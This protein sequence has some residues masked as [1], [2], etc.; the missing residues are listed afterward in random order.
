[1]HCHQPPL[2][3]DLPCKAVL[4][5]EVSVDLLCT[6]I[7]EQ[8][9]EPTSQ[10]LSLSLL[11]IQSRVDLI[12]VLSNSRL[13]LSRLGGGAGANMGEGGDSIGDS[14]GKGICGVG[15]DQG[16]NGD[17]CGDDIARSLAT[18]ESVHVGI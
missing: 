10:Q 2:G 11:I 12:H 17:A 9:V 5:S 1:M 18:S 6:P 8:H 14:G 13:K 3:C 15:E 16:D 4:D 7:P